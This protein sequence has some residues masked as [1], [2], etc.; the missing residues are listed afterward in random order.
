MSQISASYMNNTMDDQLHV[1][2]SHPN[3]YRDFS[4]SIS[5]QQQ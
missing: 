5:K 3:A 1:D 2:F 4:G